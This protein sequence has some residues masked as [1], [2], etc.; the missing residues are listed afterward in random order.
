MSVWLCLWSLWAGWV[1]Y[2][3]FSLDKMVKNIIL[4]NSVKPEGPSYSEPFFHHQM[5]AKKLNFNFKKMYILL[6]FT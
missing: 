4:L 3:F 6:F 5:L 2:G 1:K